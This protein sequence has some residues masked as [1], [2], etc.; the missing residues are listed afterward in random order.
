MPPERRLPSVRGRQLARE[1]R[2]LRAA[3]GLTGD[4]IAAELGWSSAKV[5]RIENARTTV[6]PADLRK[7]LGLYQV[8]DIQAERLLDLARTAHERG[9]WQAYAESMEKGY[10]TFISLESEATVMHSYHLTLIPGILQ[11]EDYARAIITAGGPYPHGEIDRRIRIRLTRQMRLDEKDPPAVWAVLDEAVL[12]RNIGGNR[13]MREQLAQLVSIA[14]K[15]NVNIQVLPYGSGV[16]SG[17]TGSYV[18]FGFAHPDDPNVVFLETLVGNLIV[19]D[20]VQVFK[21]DQSFDELRAKGLN[22]GDS[23]DFIL[24]VADEYE[25]RGY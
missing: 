4:Q 21:Y 15:P 14:K 7:L 10:A 23:V 13:V 11:T 6:T 17:V 12:R 22:V 2:E 1:L 9:W 24:Q 8:T 18:V 16:H 5:S 25:S 20:A 3:S 19:E